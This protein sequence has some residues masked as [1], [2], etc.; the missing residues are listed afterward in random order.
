MKAG[1]ELLR[2]TEKTLLLEGKVRYE[3]KL[4]FVAF[5]IDV[6]EKKF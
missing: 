3:R 4:I 5:V 2:K 6:Q 1:L